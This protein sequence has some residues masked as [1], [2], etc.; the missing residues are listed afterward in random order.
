ML[1]ESLRELDEPD[2]VKRRGDKL[3]KAINSLQNTVDKI[4]A[5]NMRV[6]TFYN[7]LYRLS[8]SCFITNIPFHRRCRNLMRCE[9]K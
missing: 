9:K 5:P 3:L 4:Q 2:E 1:G 7:S 6:R 8:F